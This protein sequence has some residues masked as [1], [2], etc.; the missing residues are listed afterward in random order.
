MIDKVKSPLL[1]EKSIRLLQKNQYTF[2][3][4]SDV[5]KTEFKKWIEIFFKVKVMSINS[6][7]PPR[8]KKRIGLISGYTVRYKKII[9]TLKSGDSI[10]LFS[11]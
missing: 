6:C 4:N 1:T 2:Q 9:V 10:P 5:N 7:R 8:K 11:I 3:V